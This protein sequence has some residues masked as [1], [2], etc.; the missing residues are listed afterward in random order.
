VDRGASQNIKIEGT[1]RA[2][3]PVEEVTA[4]A[5]LT[6][7]VALVKQEKILGCAANVAL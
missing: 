4:A 1:E 2:S 5:V 6:Q 7:Q 3:L